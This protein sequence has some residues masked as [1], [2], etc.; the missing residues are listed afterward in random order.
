M[1]SG[2]DGTR[3]F[4]PPASDVEIVDFGGDVGMKSVYLLNL[5]EVESTH[6][7]LCP[8][9]EVSAKFATGP[10]FWNSLLRATAQYVPSSVLRNQKLMLAFSKFSLPVVRAVDVFSGARTA[11]RVEVEFGDVARACGVYEH[12]SLRS[13]VG[14]AT[15]AF[16]CELISEGRSRKPG[17][18]FPEELA[19]DDCKA[20]KSILDDAAIG[21]DRYSVT[22]DFT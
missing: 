11:I 12:E 19:M 8:A 4:R 14:A 22:S 2:P 20:A 1:F 21:A 15:A 18:F 10:P 17:V 7:C 9:G 13:C 5:P 16:V 6:D 3:E